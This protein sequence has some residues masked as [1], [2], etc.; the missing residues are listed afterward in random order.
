MSIPLF[1]VRHKQKQFSELIATATKPYAYWSFATSASET[2]ST[3]STSIGSKTSS[4]TPDF[5]TTAGRITLDNSTYYTFDDSTTANTGLAALLNLGAGAILVAATVNINASETGQSCILSVHT[6]AG[7]NWRLGV[8]KNTTWRHD[9]NL[10]MDAETSVTQYAGSSNEFAS[11]TDV[12]LVWL[13]DNRSGV[14]TLYRWNNGTSLTGATWSGNANRGP[15]TF[16]SAVTKRVRI[17]SD[18]AGTPG[19]L[20][21]G[22]LR[23]LHV[24]NYGTGG[25]PSRINDIVA[26][27][28]ANNNRPTRLLLESIQ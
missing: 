27:L 6:G 23:R 24:V 1:P 10:A 4:G 26:S 9:I 15:C 28:H 17:G 22:S 2:I 18:S 21:W 16:A 19:S 8:T 20:F 13:I 12:N 5:A 7:P 3:P 11:G 25:P 14:W